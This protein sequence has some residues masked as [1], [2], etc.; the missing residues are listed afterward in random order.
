MLHASDVSASAQW[1]LPGWNSPWQQVVVA[2]EAVHGSFFLHQ[3]CSPS[4]SSSWPGWPLKTPSPQS[5]P[6]HHSQLLSSERIPNF[7]GLGPRLS[8]C[9]ACHP[10][11]RTSAL[12]LSSGKFQGR[13]ADWGSCSLPPYQM[14]MR[15]STKSEAFA[16]SCKFGA[17]TVLQF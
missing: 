15:P 5:H 14:T 3:G 7:S 12:L 4:E 1:P 9:M 2:C 16:C 13:G 8:A 17:Q 11:P 10:D 6:A